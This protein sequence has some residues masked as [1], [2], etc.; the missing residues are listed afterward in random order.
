M[1]KAL[2]FGSRFVP[3]A[4]IPE[5]TY[6]PPTFVRPSH[7]GASA[8]CVIGKLVVD[9]EVQRF[10]RRCAATDRELRPG[11]SFYSV[12]K[13]EGADVVR[14]DYASETWQGPPDDALGWWKSEVPDPKANRVHWAP[15][16]IMLHYFQQLT[17]DP[18][19]QDV[20]YVLA[21]LLIRR[22]VFKL[23]ASQRSSDGHEE[24]VVY[25]SKKEQQYHIP[26]VHPEPERIQAIQQELAAT[27][28]AKAEDSGSSSESADHEPQ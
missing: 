19:K 4:S 11:E 24:L 8:F 27:L 15:N 12:L 16:D 1:V 3:L 9:F 14:Y 13:V 22:R 5:I 26:V 2:R 18:N 7:A 10:T 17:A 25:C 6:D 23:E 21:L 20:A 28:F